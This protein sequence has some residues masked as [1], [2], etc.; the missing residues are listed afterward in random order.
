MRLGLERDIFSG[1][2]APGATLNE[3][4]I[5]EAYEVSRTP[6]REAIS[7][8]VRAG[9]ITKQAQR[10]AVVTPLNVEKLLELFE[11]LA[12][13]E[14]IAARLAAERMS[15]PEKEALLDLHRRA[16]AVVDGEPNTYSDLGREFHRDILK[17]CKNSAL[18]QA[19]AAL[20]TR[21]NPFRRFQVLAP[22]RIRT[23]Q[24]DHERIV[25]AIVDGDGTR[26]GAALRQH[27]SDQGDMLVRFIALHKVS[28][29][30]TSTQGRP[31]SAAGY[32]TQSGDR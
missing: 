6:V 22:D 2:L 32:G 20:A 4:H 12:E 10:R 11:A 30:D 26:A 29:S 17:G 27:T 31:A 1:R 28:Y 5:A 16:Q 25:R 23:N 21:V 13:L 7:A 18:I 24:S 8:L 19:T 9:L 15:R 14:G 3:S